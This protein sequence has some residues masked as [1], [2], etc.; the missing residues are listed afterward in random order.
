M[1]RWAAQFRYAWRRH[2]PVGLVRLTFYNLAYT[3]RRT[4]RHELTPQQLDSFDAKYGTDT[5]GIREIRT[6]DAAALP[7]ARYAVRLA[8]VVN[9]GCVKR[10]TS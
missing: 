8:R 1:I 3:I 7:N 6:L 5:D 4:H 9:K 10:S 2:G